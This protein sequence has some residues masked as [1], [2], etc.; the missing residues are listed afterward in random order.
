M[1]AKK[2]KVLSLL[3]LPG[4]L[5][6]AFIVPDVNACS[7]FTMNSWP[8]EDI[9]FTYIASG[10]SHPPYVFSSPSVMEKKTMVSEHN[11]LIHITKNASCSFFYDYVCRLKSPIQPEMRKK[12][13][14]YLKIIFLK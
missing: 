10:P 14:T 7:L 11:I 1:K 8:S 4:P 3:Y 6:I 13:F 5:N 12:H 9:N 2:V